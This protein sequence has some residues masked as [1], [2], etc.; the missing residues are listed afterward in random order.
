[1]RVQGACFHACCCLLS[2]NTPRV[3]GVSLL[4]AA[5]ARN[6]LVSCCEDLNQRP[7]QDWHVPSAHW[8][9]YVHWLRQR[10]AYAMRPALELRGGSRCAAY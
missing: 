4:L 1:M 8:Q 7:A 3:P 10:I 6:E 9:V 2:G 5:W